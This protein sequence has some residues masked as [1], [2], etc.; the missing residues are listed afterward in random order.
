MNATSTRY[1]RIAELEV[2]PAQLDAFGS[3]IAEQIEAAVRVE[4]GVLVLY[5]VSEKD[6][7]ARVRVFEIYADADAYKTH[8]QTPHFLKFR[9][10]TE[11]MIRS[12]KLID[13]V[14]IA[15]AAKAS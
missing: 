15:L 2:D 11:N 14:P 3:A 9:A 7:P 8:L 5:A 6:N 10:I 12:R 1:V 4:P 13:A